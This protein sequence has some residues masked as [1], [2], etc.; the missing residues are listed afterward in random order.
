MQCYDGCV[1]CLQIHTMAKFKCEDK[2]LEVDRFLSIKNRLSKE[3]NVL[4]RG[5][6]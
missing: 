3:V 1:T 6:Q 5:N 4:L 2:E